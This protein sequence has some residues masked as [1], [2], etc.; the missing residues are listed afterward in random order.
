MKLK[1]IF[2]YVSLKHLG[3]K[4]CPYKTEHTFSTIYVKVAT[5]YTWRLRNV[6][7][8]FDRTRKKALSEMPWNKIIC[9]IVPQRIYIY[10]ICIP[11]SSAKMAAI[12][13]FNI[14]W[15]YITSINTADWCTKLNFA[16]TSFNFRNM[17]IFR[18]VVVEN[19]AFNFRCGCLEKF[20]FNIGL[21]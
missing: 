13:S 20:I 10:F 15:F 5:T 14:W 1:N 7:R 18:P 2:Y 11:V 19:F 17:Y 8:Y 12:Q 9:A 4:S 3:W 21:P 16:T 6:I